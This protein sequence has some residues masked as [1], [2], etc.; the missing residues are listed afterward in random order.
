M[1]EAETLIWQQ[2]LTLQ[3]E[4]ADDALVLDL[5]LQEKQ[6]MPYCSLHTAVLVICSFKLWG[7]CVAQSVKRLTLDFSSGHDSRVMGL[8]PASGSALNMEPA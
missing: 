4:L 6:A 7:G 1:L 3:P 8:N 2:S 5:D